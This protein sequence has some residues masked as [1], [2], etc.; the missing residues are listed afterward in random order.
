MLKRFFS[1]FMLL[2][3]LA[4][5][6]LVL[7]A[8]SEDAQNHLSTPSRQ[9]LSPAG[10]L[11]GADL[12]ALATHFGVSVPYIHAGGSGIVKDTTYAGGY[13]RAF[14][15]SDPSGLTISAVRPASAAQLLNPG[16][17]SFDASQTYA[18]HDMK[19]VMATDANGCFLFFSDDF[20]A[21]CLYTNN[22]PHA[23][24]TLMNDIKFTN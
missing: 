6:S 8:G 1:G 18:I 22:S 12:N 3:T 5:F 2:L 20:A 9:T 10:L 13:A 21:Y 15:Y 7:I 17:L 24:T 19:A 23:L 11:S 4:I 16:G 14:T